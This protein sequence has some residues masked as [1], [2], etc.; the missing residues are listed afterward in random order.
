MMRCFPP[1]TVRGSVLAS[2][3]S[4]ITIAASAA[5][6]RFRP[7]AWTRDSS[8]SIGGCSGA[9]HNGDGTLTRAITDDILPRMFSFLALDMVDSG[10]NDRF[11]YLCRPPTGEREH[12]HMPIRDLAAAWDATKALLF[13]EGRNGEGEGLR[14]CKHETDGTVI[15]RRILRVVVCCTLEAYQPLTPIRVDGG[16]EDQDCS[17]LT[18]NAHMLKETANIAH[19][20]L[21]IMAS[22]NAHRLSICPDFDI[23]TTVCGL[24][25]G[26]LSN[27][28]PDG[29]FRI[30][31]DGQDESDVYKGIDFFPGE[32]M[33]AL[34]DAYD[35]SEKSGSILNEHAREAIV[36]CLERAYMFYCDY[37]HEEKPD[38]NFNI[39]QIISLSRFYDVLGRRG[40][41]DQAA[42]VAH[43]V[44]NMC[45]EIV[46]SRAWKEL[47]Q[48]QSF[49]ANLNTVEIVCGLDA[50]AEGLR[51]A[52]SIGDVETAALFKRNAMNAVYFVEWSQ[53][54]VSRDSSRGFGG[55]GFGGNHVVEQRLDVTGH[56]ISALVKLC[57][58]DL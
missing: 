24:V 38:V 23:E 31:F 17:A 19:S 42:F 20:A 44:L 13:L 6:S 49:Y 25:Q 8:L 2:F 3:F 51:L 15:I 32:A 7:C 53:S 5:T 9:V 34:M 47:K 43:H 14:D 58:L 27:Q 10:E 40:R 18:L 36:S 54:Q 35:L 50:L 22:A 46:V 11:Y 55:L 1:K 56:A 52:N 39:W 12:R 48:G 21:L 16:C 41:L 4:F 45:R 37:Y 26:I 57:L 30:E 28:R 29:A 33:L